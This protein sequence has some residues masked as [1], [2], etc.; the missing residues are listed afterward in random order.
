M[1]LLVS[2]YHSTALTRF[3]DKIVIVVDNT[4]CWGPLGCPF[5]SVCKSAKFYN[6]HLN[7][8]TRR[9]T[10]L[11]F[12]QILFQNH[13]LLDY[14]LANADRH[15]FAEQTMFTKYCQNCLSTPLS[16]PCIGFLSAQSSVGIPAALL[17]KVNCCTEM[18]ILNGKNFNF[19]EELYSAW[20]AL[21]NA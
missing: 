4:D 11:D 10:F 8:V 16:P 7:A 3:S 21:R 18:A 14:L 13:S 9:S 6:H 5:V 15:L 20:K 12:F 2:S 1:S 19:S 17:S